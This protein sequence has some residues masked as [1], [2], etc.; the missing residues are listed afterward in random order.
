M[1]KSLKLIWIDRHVLCEIFLSIASQTQTHTLTLINTE[2]S[3]RI[4]LNVRW[5]NNCTVHNFSF[6]LKSYGLR[7]YPSNFTN[8]LELPT[9]HK[10]NIERLN[11]WRSISTEQREEEE[12][13]IAHNRVMIIISSLC[14]P[15]DLWSLLNKKR[16]EKTKRCHL[17]A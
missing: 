15:C 14:I 9:W 12:T 1:A 2:I 11:K 4:A 17:V 13:T 7:C 3:H 5:V 16:K 6:G 10:T 8:R